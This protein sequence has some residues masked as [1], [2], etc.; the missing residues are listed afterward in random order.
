MHIL[1][2]KKTWCW[3]QIRSQVSRPIKAG[4]AGGTDLEAVGTEPVDRSLTIWCFWCGVFKVKRMAC[5]GQDRNF[6]GVIAAERGV[7]F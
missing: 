7:A 5:R 1:Q 3:S 2:Q 4:T 6:R